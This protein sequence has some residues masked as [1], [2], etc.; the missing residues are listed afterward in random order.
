MQIANCISYYGAD[1]VLFGTDF[2]LPTDREFVPALDSL[3]DLYLK[4]ETRAKIE[5]GNIEKLLHL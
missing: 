1:H 3:N 5:H 4:D 2:P